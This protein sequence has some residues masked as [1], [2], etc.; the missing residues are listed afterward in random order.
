[1]KPIIFIPGIEATRLVDTNSF[2][3]DTI[4]NAYDTLGTSLASK[5]TGPHIDEPLQLNP[6]YD[7][8][9]SVIV[10][11]DT[12]AS[13]P[14]QNTFASLSKKIPDPIFPFGYDWRLS[15]AVNA[16]RLKD[17]VQYLQRKLQ[18]TTG[19]RFITHSMGGLIFSC[20]LRQI[21][22]Y[23]HI[24]KVILCAPPFMGSPYALVHMVK[25]SGG[26][27][28]FI[29]K[30]LGQNDDIRKIVRTYPGLFEI[31]PVYPGALTYTN[32]QSPVDLLRLDNW[33]SNVCDDK[34]NAIIDLFPQRLAALARF[35]W[36]DHQDYTL[37]DVQL[38]KKIIVVAGID[39]KTNSNTLTH[40]PV[41]RQQS[42]ILNFLQL[43][44][45]N[46]KTNNQSGDGTVPKVSSTWFSDVLITIGVPKDGIVDQLG[47]N[48]DFHGMFLRDSRV[49]NII[50]RYF[51]N[52]L[53]PAAVSPAGTLQPDPA[54]IGNL[55]YFA[56]GSLPILPRG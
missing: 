30:I 52:D 22:N 42:D 15:N 54:V 34:D 9:A 53:Y 3:F 4:W 37:L 5:F 26:L 13:L 19:F 35:R 18:I 10:G 16:T 8:S 17:F 29:S 31:L 11:R 33:Q 44:G 27:R 36:N 28:G 45:I 6:L 51:K 56:G 20:Y 41:I 12:V 46:D 24:D 40:L 43:D 50:A 39:P 32:D 38:R 21:S 25:G 47:D 14:Y 2:G 23:D 48:I 49:Q 7:V 55:C 1:M